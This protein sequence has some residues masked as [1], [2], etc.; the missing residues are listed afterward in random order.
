MKTLQQKIFVLLVD[1]VFPLVGL[2]LFWWTMF[3]LTNNESLIQLSILVGLIFGISLTLYL[4]KFWKDSIYMLSGKVVLSVY[5]FYNFGVFGF[6]MGVPVF[7]PILGIFAALY[8]AQRIK[9]KSTQD[10]FVKNEINKIILIATVVLVFVFSASAYFA[11]NDPYTAGMVEHIFHLPFSV[12][13]SMLVGIIIVGGIGLL[14][15]QYLA[16]KFVFGRVLR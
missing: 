3:F 13:T 11:L 14:V 10:A 16:M 5:L 9:E 8:W 7:H 12:S 6:F 15:F 1:A 4:R 2:L